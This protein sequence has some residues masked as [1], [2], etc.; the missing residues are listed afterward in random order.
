[1]NEGLSLNQIPQWP[2]KF[3]K[4]LRDLGITTAEQV[5]SRGTITRKKIWPTI[6]TRPRTRWTIPSTCRGSVSPRTWQR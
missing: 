5:V 6:S 4:R 3:V 1:M 2:E